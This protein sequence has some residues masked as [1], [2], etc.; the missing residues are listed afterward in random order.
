VQD[1]RWKNDPK[2]KLT[3]EESIEDMSIAVGEDLLPFFCKTGK[4]LKRKRITKVSFLGETLKLA[5]AP[6]EPTPPGDV[7][8]DPIGDYKQPIKIED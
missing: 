1:Q 3:W 2:R 4:E 6:I 5:P 8:L 7:C